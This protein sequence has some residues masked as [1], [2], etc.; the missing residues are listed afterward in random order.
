MINKSTNTQQLNWNKRWIKKER[1]EGGKRT[2]E[3]ETVNCG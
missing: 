2:S 3:R 1:K